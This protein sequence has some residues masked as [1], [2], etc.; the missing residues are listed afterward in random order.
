VDQGPY[1]I[2]S[3]SEAADAKKIIKSE[4]SRDNYLQSTL[5]FCIIQNYTLVKFNGTLVVKL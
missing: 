2:K 5:K 1:I 4:V 3:K